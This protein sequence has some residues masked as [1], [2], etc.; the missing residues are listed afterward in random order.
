MVLA[1]FFFVFPEE[2]K[3]IVYSLDSYLHPALSDESVSVIKKRDFQVLPRDEHE[4][5]RERGGER[6][7]DMI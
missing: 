2:R 4:R 6:E 5:E 7:N 3:E 1:L